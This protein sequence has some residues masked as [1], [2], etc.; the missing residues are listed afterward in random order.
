M[1]SSTLSLSLHSPAFDGEI[2]VKSMMMRCGACNRYT[3]EQE[4]PVC[5]GPVERRAPARYSPQDRFGK[6]RRRLTEEAEKDGQ[7]EED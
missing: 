4:C 7:G 3:M 1:Y 6:Y 5:K 2:P